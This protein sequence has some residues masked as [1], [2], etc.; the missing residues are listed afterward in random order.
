MGYISFSEVARNHGMAT[1]HSG[2]GSP[3]HLL[4]TCTAESRHHKA[5]LRFTVKESLVKKARWQPGDRVDVLWDPEAKM[6]LMKRVKDGGFALS[7]KKDKKT[8]E[9]E[10]SGQ[11]QFV[12]RSEM[13][14]P[15]VP[16]THPIVQADVTD[17]GIMFELPASFGAG[18]QKDCGKSPEG[19]NCPFEVSES[20]RAS[21][22]E[23]DVNR[24]QAILD[25][26]QRGDKTILR[27][28]VRIEQT[29]RR[30]K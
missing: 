8:G 6:G 5:R 25:G 27:D 7:F 10:P 18:P 17:E 20:T 15:F 29:F 19:A 4:L 28:P 16:G 26:P 3:V 12:Y 30:R 2:P 22:T 9:Y 14:M 1:R 21:F 24:V 11:V 13:G 23:A